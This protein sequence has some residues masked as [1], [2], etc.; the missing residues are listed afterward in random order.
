MTAAVLADTISPTRNFVA[1][2]MLGLW[3]LKARSS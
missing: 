1:T 2:D 3:R